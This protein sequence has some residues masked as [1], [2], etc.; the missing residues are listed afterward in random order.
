MED[1]L[2]EKDRLLLDQEKNLLELTEKV[3]DLK[4][5][6][7]DLSDERKRLQELYSKT[8]TAFEESQ[9]KNETKVAN[10]L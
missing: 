2:E 8:K 3:S 1:S 9:Q 7:E 4:K 5:N 6:L 10:L